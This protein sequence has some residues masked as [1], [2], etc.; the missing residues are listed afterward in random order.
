LWNVP[1][2]EFLREL[3]GHS[4]GVTSVAFS[5]DGRVVTGSSD[6]TLRIWDVAGE[7]RPLRHD[8]DV[9]AGGQV[10]AAPRG[11]TAFLDV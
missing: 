5:A 3:K 1:T 2:G 4:D 8:G 6:R 7:P 9:M 10:K 11:I